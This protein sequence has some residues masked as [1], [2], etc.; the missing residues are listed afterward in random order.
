M[1][2]IYLL[3]PLSF[4]SS[5]SR[6]KRFFTSKMYCHGDFFPKKEGLFL[7]PIFFKKIVVPQWEIKMLFAKSIRGKEGNEECTLLKSCKEC[8]MD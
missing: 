3:L 1:L 2:C 7:H 6:K 4:T 5:M 8:F